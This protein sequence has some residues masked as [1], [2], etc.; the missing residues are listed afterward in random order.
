MKTVLTLVAPLLIMPALALAQAAPPA[1]P[2]WLSEA[3]A[4]VKVF[5]AV[6]TGLGTM[7]GLP[8]VLLSFK[9]T[10]A[11]IRKLELEAAAL[12]GKANAEGAVQAGTTIEI[13]HSHDLNIQV[14]ADPRFLGPLLLLLDFILAWVIL[15]LAGTFLNIIDLGVISSVLLAVLAMALLVPI[16]KEARRVKRALKL[17]TEIAEQSNGPPKSDA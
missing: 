16:A 8:I 3:D 12:Q 17:A 6:L 9:K 4:Y 7:F 14:L 5:G 15:T 11:E 10:R 13:S 1:S 2:T